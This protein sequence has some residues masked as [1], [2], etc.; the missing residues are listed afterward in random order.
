MPVLAKG[1]TDTGR[2]WVYV[3]DDSPFGGPAPPAAVFYYSRD[4][5]GEHPQAHLADYTG[6][7][8]A[9]AYG[10]YGKLYEPEPQAWADHGGGLL[11]PCPAPVLRPGRSGRERASQGCRARSRPS[12]RR[13]R[14]RSCAGSTPCSRSS[15]TINGQSADQRKAVRQE[16]SAPLVADLEAWMREQRAKLS[17]GN[18]VAKAMDYMLKRWTVASRASS[19]TAASACPT[20][21]PSGRCAASHLG[22]KSW[23]FCGSDRGG[24]RAAVMYSLIVTA[25][26]ND[27]DPQAWLADVLA[28]IAEHPAQK[29]DELLPWNWQQL[30]EPV[31]QAA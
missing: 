12:S 4:R 24:E 1:K 17:R 2:C 23:L 3:R 27:V 13:W 29:L 26:M 28:R 6:I 7:L 20:T 25:K 15:A 21:P 9:D 10:G 18:D 8:Q 5:G 22:R 16:L 19:T 31:S 14:S 11:G 30:K